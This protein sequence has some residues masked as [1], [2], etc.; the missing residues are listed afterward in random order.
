MV[1]ALG[2][3]RENAAKPVQVSDVA[4]ETGVS[5]RV[6]ERRF[7]QA[8]GR[9]PA[10]EIRRVHLERAKSLLVG[11]DLPIPEVADAAGFGSSEYFAY[12]FKTEMRKTPLQ[13]RKE[14]RSR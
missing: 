14:I 4:Q 1:K 3:I 5:R 6:L 12:V 8:L 9:S 10:T 11:T 7:L 2:F 13:Y